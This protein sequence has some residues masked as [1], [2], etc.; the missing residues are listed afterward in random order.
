MWRGEET[1]FWKSVKSRN[2]RGVCANGFFRL[3]HQLDNCRGGDRLW[4][5]ASA[6]I[7]SNESEA[8]GS[9]SG[10]KKPNQSDPNQSA[11][12]IDWPTIRWLVLVQLAREKKTSLKIDSSLPVWP[13]SLHT[14]IACTFEF[15]F[16]SIS[17]LTTSTVIFFFFSFFKFEQ[18]RPNFFSKKLCGS[19][20]LLAKVK[21]VTYYLSD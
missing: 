3:R 14:A 1:S 7:S 20:N 5:R 11:L 9:C 4:A 21:I 6:R 2:S 12:K 13:G 16:V 10:S 19:F 18:D 8:G 17:L 15:Y